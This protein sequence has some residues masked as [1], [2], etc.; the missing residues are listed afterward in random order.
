MNLD[1]I[2]F[3]RESAEQ[4]FA[5]LQENGAQRLVDT[6][7]YPSTQLS[8]F[9]KTKDLAWLLGEAPTCSYVRMKEMAARTGNSAGLPQG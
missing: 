1:T 9:A 8:G 5:L 3:T 7:L 6:R 2:G 4:F